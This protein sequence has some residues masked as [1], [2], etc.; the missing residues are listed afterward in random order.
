MDSMQQTCLE[1][2][3]SAERKQDFRHLANNRCGLRSR[4]SDFA[5]Y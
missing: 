1:I 2:S 3:A 5:G 4:R